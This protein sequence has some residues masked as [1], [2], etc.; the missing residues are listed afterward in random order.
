VFSIQA[1]ITVDSAS[2]ATGVRKLALAINGTRTWQQV[3]DN[4]PSTTNVARLNLAATSALYV[5]DYVQVS[6]YQDSGVALN[7]G[8]STV[9][10]RE[11]QLFLCI[12]RI[13]A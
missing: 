8:S 2:S 11:E 12:T 4:H 7:A 3:V 5:G 10:A 6:V 13:G 9:A 1:Y